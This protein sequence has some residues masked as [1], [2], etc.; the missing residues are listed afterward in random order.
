MEPEQFKKKVILDHTEI[1]NKYYYSTTTG[2]T[3]SDKL[4]KRLKKDGHKITLKTIKEFI[5]KQEVSQIHKQEKTVVQSFI[6]TSRK[7]QYQIDLIYLE[8]SNLNKQKK[9]A[10]TCI[11]AFTKVLNIQLLAKRDSKSVVDA[12][13]RIIVKEGATNSIYSD[14]GSEFT[15]K[16]FKKLMNKY[17]IDH[18]ISLSHATMIESVHRTIK[19]MLA[20]YKTSTQ[21]KTWHTIIDDI[22]DNYNNT[23]HN[24]IEM[25]PNEVDDTNEHI[26]QMNI[27][28]HS[29]KSVPPKEDLQVNDNVRIKENIKDVSFKKGYYKKWSAEV[30]KIT[31]IVGRRYKINNNTDISY[32]RSHL[33]KVTDVEVNPNTPNLNNTTEGMLKKQNKPIPK[34]LSPMEHKELNDLNEQP[35]IKTKK[36]IQK[37]LKQDGIDEN[38]IIQDKYKIGDNIKVNIKD[39]NGKNRWYIGTIMKKRGKKHFIKWKNDD[40]SEWLNLDEEDVKK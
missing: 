20:K 39:D 24:T 6:P 12:M 33:Q 25:T 7:Q 4:Y 28:K 23:Y 35:V 34:H 19:M 18:I 3:S 30:Y 32:V 2:F 14:E 38:N 5:K 9:Y 11:N 40:P 27:I 26:V 17:E 36:E 21:S 13:E 8:D 31:Q 29:R 1:L 16:E 22:V 10:L 15:N 37:V